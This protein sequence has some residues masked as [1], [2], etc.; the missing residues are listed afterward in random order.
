[1]YI[2]GKDISPGK[3]KVDGGGY[4]TRLSGLPREFHEIIANDNPE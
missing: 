1:M 4:W 3:Y 2:V